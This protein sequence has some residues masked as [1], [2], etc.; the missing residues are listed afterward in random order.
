MEFTVY[1]SNNPGN[2][3]KW[4]IYTNNE[5]I[6]TYTRYVS[7]VFVSDEKT[8]EVIK[9]KRIEESEES[10]DDEEIELT[11]FESDKFIFEKI[12]KH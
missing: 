2:K 8:T 7:I 3:T 12:L 11:S 6:P 4:M 10:S 9:F 1:A 5:I